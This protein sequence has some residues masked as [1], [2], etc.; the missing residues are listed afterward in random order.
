MLQ[1]ATLWLL[2]VLV[3]PTVPKDVAEEY[4]TNFVQRKVGRIAASVKDTSRAA[5]KPW[6]VRKYVGVTFH[7]SGTVFLR[8]LFIH[9]FDALGAGPFDIGWTSSYNS[10]DWVKNHTNVLF[11][12]APIQLRTDT[13]WPALE[14]EIREAAAPQPIRIAAIVR[15]PLD[16]VASAYCYH[17]RG[18]ES[19]N[20]QFFPQGTLQSMGP[21]EGTAFVAER[22]FGVVQNM[23]ESFETPKEDILVIRYEDIT[24]SS[25]GFDEATGKLLDFFFAGLLSQEEYNSTLEASRQVDLNRFPLPDKEKGH[26]SDAACV[27]EAKQAALAMPGDLLAPFH[28]FQQRLGYPVA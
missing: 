24:A 21:K 17:H 15:D 14:Q 10:T 27:A 20:L 2:L 8:D 7:K 18:E 11:P 5:V 28:S 16:M 22:M 9:L 13:W 3:I 26:T 4:A 25:K 19:D 1:R 6:Q 23:T 12:E